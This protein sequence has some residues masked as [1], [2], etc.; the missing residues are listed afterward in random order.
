MVHGAIPPFVSD[1]T[2]SAEH[3]QRWFR[4]AKAA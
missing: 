2:A 3:A 4:R 1:E